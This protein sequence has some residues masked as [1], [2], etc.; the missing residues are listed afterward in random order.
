MLSDLDI[1]K[2]LKDGDIKISP[3]EES[4][5]QPSSIDLRVGMILEFLKI[6]NIHI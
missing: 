3:M 2:A 1:K 6:I 4:F 5:I